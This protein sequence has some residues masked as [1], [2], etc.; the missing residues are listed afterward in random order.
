MCFICEFIDGGLYKMN[1]ECN[2]VDYSDSHYCVFKHINYDKT[3]ETLMIVPHEQ[4]KFIT[5][6]D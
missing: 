1:G 6:E 2:Y 4:I 5:K 3:E